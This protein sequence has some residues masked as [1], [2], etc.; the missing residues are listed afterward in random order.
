MPSVRTWRCHL[1]RKLAALALALGLGLGAWLALGLCAHTAHAD[2]ASEWTEDL[3]EQR[4]LQ[5][6]SEGFRDMF[7]GK[8]R[9]YWDRGPVFETEKKAFAVHL[10]WE[11]QT[12]FIA[13]GDMKPAVVSA[14]GESW[15][16]GPYLRRN[17]VGIEAFLLRDWFFRVR[18]GWNGVLEFQDAFVEWSGLRNSHLTRNQDWMPVVRV[19]QL[20]EAMTMD[21]M[22]NAKWPLFAERGMFTT[23]IVPNRTP[24]IRFHG[25][26]FNRR[27]TYQ[28]G[29]FS[30]NNGLAPNT[31]GKGESI[32]GRI[33]GL[34]WAPK[35][36][37]KRLLH[38]GVSSTW[39]KN[40]G[41]V[42][43]N[44]RAESWRGPSIVDTG[45]FSAEE[46]NATAVEALFQHDRFTAMVEAAWT[47]VTLPGGLTANY[48]GRYGAVSYYLIGPGLNY[49]R[50]MAVLG[51]V[52]PRCTAI[53]PSNGWGA[54]EVTARYSM[55]DL[56][57]GPFPGGIA[58][59][60]TLGLNWYPRD[61]MRVTLNYI[62]TNVRNAYGDPN[63]D[64]SL[65]TMMMRLQYDL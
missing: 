4:T 31:P 26:G 60:V 14:G 34:P 51:R 28:I 38:L 53:A 35:G 6:V 19:G 40:V 55:L 11:V 43:F 5:R 50:S 30:A 64:G 63:A 27:L 33:T 21:W 17:R 18:Y 61:N 2:D 3:R 10:G 16:S 65:N 9:F 36:H 52:H 25:T 7:R 39:R 32:T 23:S 8:E 49:V 47:H 42:R 12:D 62:R 29:A 54:F 24:G 56:D 57:S 41:G 45:T 44:S 22:H 13:Y 59:A 20:K 15:D 37:P 58:K 1:G 48:R 46:W